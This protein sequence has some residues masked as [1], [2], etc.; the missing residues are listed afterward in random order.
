MIERESDFL[1]GNTFNISSPEIEFRVSTYIF[2]RDFSILI[3]NYLKSIQSKVIPTILLGF[4]ECI[5]AMW[6]PK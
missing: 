5:N 2:S 1:L 6:I 4:K 3:F